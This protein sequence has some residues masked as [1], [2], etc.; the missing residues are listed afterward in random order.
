MQDNRRERRSGVMTAPVRSVIRAFSVLQVV[1]ASQLS[2]GLAQIAKATRLPKSSV[3]RMLNTLEHL[4]MVER[5]GRRGRYRVGP[6]LEV[7]AGGGASPQ[8]LK[9]LGRPHLQDLVSQLGEDATLSVPEG[10]EVLYISQITA[11]RAVKVQ[12]WSGVTFPHHTV[13]P[14]FIFLSTWEPD[15]LESYLD[16]DLVSFTPNTLVDPSALR[17]RLETVRRQGYS[18]THRES[19]VDITGAAAAVTGPHG[20]VV[21]ALS[22][23]GPSYRFP[24]DRGE[25]EIGALMRSVAD[26]LTA[27]LAG[28]PPRIRSQ[29]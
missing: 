24:A 19:A 29:P 18:W 28:F 23:H 15:R 14:G 5:V 13:A 11:D 22:V 26:R 9:Q 16:G 21:A 1:A 10:D 27:E 12:D 20:K 4:D 17:V 7:L 25:S 3:S 8:V 6:G 2:A